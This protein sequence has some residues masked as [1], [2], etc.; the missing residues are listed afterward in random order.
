V[1][2]SGA[3]DIC[4]TDT[5]SDGNWHY[6]VHVFSNS[7]GASGHHRLYID[8]V[9]EATGNYGYSNR[10]AQARIILGKTPVVGEYFLGWIDDVKIWNRALTDDEIE[11]EYHKL[12]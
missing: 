6:A 12:L 8:G 4:S 2:V 5:Y 7:S 9:L 11:E 1:H 10:T 3:D